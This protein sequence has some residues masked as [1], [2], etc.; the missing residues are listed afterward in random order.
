M[1]NAVIERVFARP[2]ASI[3][4]VGG[5]MINRAARVE[6]GGERY[7]VKTINSAPAGF[8]AAEADGLE[9]LRAANALRVPQVIAHDEARDGLPAYLILEWID[10]APKSRRLSENL[11]RGLAAQHRVTSARYGLE[12]D[13]FIGA[14]PQA[15]GFAETW[16]A[17]YRDRRISPQVELARRRGLLPPERERLLRR[18]IDRLDDL[19]GGMESVPSLLHG[20]LWSGNYMACDGDQPVVIDPAV[21]Y[22][23]REVE[24][25]FTELFGGFSDRFYAAYDEAYPLDPGYAARRPL[26]QVYPLLVHLN[27]FGESYGAHVEAACRPYV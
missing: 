22:G 14:L 15:N 18:V 5:G 2:A 24:L 23:S 26:H 20:D 19:L 25:A 1:L 6:V 11:G 16:S 13:N 7:F 12:R 27:L 21:Y 10:D 4:P 9:R 8:F 17:F 3:Q